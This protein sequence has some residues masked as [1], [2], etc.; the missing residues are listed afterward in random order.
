VCYLLVVC[1]RDRFLPLTQSFPLKLLHIKR[2]HYWL[3]KTKTFLL[4]VQRIA[5]HQIFFLFLLLIILGS[6][7]LNAMKMSPCV[8][9]LR[10]TESKGSLPTRIVWCVDDR[11]VGACVKEVAV[12]HAVGLLCHAARAV[13]HAWS[14]CY[15][16][17]AMRN[18]STS[19]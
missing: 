7:K 2:F 3:R 12:N 14:M 6:C 18:C 15:L 1:C 11:T 16:E 19:Q 5:L 8:S 9:V 17:Q 10:V 13:L 4:F